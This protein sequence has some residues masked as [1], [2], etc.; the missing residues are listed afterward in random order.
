MRVVHVMEPGFGGVLRHVEGLVAS[1]LA[2]GHQ[3]SLA[4][5]TVRTSPRLWDLIETVRRAGGGLCDLRVGNAP[6]WRDLAAAHQ[7]RKLICQQ[8]ADIV[9]AHS[10]KAG[11]LAR[12]TAR[13]C[14]CPCLYTPNAYYGMG[15]RG[16]R[17]QFFNAIERVLSRL[18]VT[19]NVSP[20]EIDFAR[21]H[22]GVPA[23][24]Q[25]LVPNGVDTSYFE[26]ATPAQKL[27]ARQALGLPPDAPVLGSLGR[28]SYQKNPEVLY[29]SF[30]LFV[31]RHPRARL[32]HLGEGELEGVLTAILQSEDLGEKVRRVE[33]LADPRPFYHALDGFA[34]TSR[35]EGLPISALEALACDLP[36]V[37]TDAPGN[38]LFGTLGLNRLTYVPVGDVEGVARGFES[39]LEGQDTP[40]NHRQVCQSRLS[41][42]QTCAQVL[43]LYHER[44]SA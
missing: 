10:S 26:P 34:L 3:V 9:H 24:L 23:H 36:L 8:S 33:G 15:R 4:Y 44:L 17:S 5:S 31:R 11:A 22:L 35:F 37:L 18:A 38:R 16:L 39:W 6:G 42:E 40:P 30:A 43:A 28:L 29:R 2:A 13:S 25:R 32:L 27:A 7:L 41:L 12:L 1:Q 14:R 19:V 21:R 20:E